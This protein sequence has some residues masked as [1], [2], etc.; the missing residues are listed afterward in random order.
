MG[1]VCGNVNRRLEPLAG[2]PAQVIDRADHVKGVALHFAGLA[3]SHR[4]VYGNWIQ[5]DVILSANPGS[6]AVP[7]QAIPPARDTVPLTLLFPSECN[8]A[9]LSDIP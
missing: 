2:R 1:D 9:A 6:Q 5:A 4:R 8:Y 3:I 7:V